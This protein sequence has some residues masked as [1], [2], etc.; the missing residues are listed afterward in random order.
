[1]AEN[2]NKISQIQVGD[3]TY[4]ICDATSRGGLLRWV[5]HSYNTQQNYTITAASTWQKTTFSIVDPF[6]GFNIIHFYIGFTN[7]QGSA[8]SPTIY[9]AAFAGSETIGY[10]SGGTGHSGFT[11]WACG[12]TAGTNWMSVRSAHSD[13]ASSHIWAY[14]GKA[15]AQ[16][17]LRYHSFELLWDDS[18]ISTNL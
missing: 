3:I 2:P 1:M 15:N 12:S 5:A 11:A 4:D 7:L 9:G 14:S 18:A 16:I 8:S 10:E 13:A 17:H 6:G